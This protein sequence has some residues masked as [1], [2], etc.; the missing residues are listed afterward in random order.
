MNNEKMLLHEVLGAVDSYDMH[1]AK[2]GL[3]INIQIIDK[4]NGSTSCSR[5]SFRSIKKAIKYLETDP[6]EIENE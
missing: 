1:K 5:E 2:K 6:E 3:T 4:N